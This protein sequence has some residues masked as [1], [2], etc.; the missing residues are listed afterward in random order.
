MLA[1]E[2]LERHPLASSAVLSVDEF[3]QVHA[4]RLTLA[5]AKTCSYEPIATTRVRMFLERKVGKAWI[6]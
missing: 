1:V 4:H 3:Q 5:S 6:S 2:V